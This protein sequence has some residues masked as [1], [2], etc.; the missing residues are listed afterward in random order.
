MI[1]K[2]ARDAFIFVK[3]NDIKVVLA[4]LHSRDAHPVIQFVKYGICGVSSVIAHNVVVYLVGI[5][6]PFAESSGLSNAE[7]SNNQIIA[8]LIAFP[9][10][11]TVAYITNALWVFTGGRH[12]RMREFIYFTIISLVSFLAGLLGGPWLVRYFN[13]S[14]HIAQAGFVFTSALVNFVCRKFFVFQK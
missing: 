6:I 7:R 9:I 4:A 1:V 10:G 2:L 14:E 13:M 12:S 8:N 5:W 3:D 11:N